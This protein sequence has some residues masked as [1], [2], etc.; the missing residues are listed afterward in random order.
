MKHSRRSASF[1]ILTLLVLMLAACSDNPLSTEALEVTERSAAS[2]ASQATAQVASST[3]ANGTI[4]QTEITSLDVRSAG[5][6]TILKQT[7][8]G[9]I[10]GTLTGSFE[11]E[12]RV[13]IHPNGT[14][15]TKF[16]LTCACTVDGKAG[17]LTIT[18]ADRG[19]LVSPDLASF[20]GRATI[21]KGTDE[22]TD[23]RGVFEIEGTVD[24]ASGL[25]TYSYSGKMRWVTR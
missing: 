2:K 3:A 16:I 23:L 5:P 4:T 19:E 8:R 21:K 22:L 12:L 7:S 24:V 10:D 11:D 18:A 1:A 20:S 6:N 14:F 15:T 25:S 17:V 13:S 9:V